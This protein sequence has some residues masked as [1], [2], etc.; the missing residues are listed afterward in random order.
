MADGEKFKKNMQEGA[1]ATK[2]A[3][4]AAES[5][6]ENIKDALFFSRD[7]ADEAKKAVKE[8]GD[9]S[10]AA[11]ETA[12]AFRD[13]ASAAKGITDNYAEVLTGEK[14]LQ[15]LIK[16]RQKL[17]AAQNSFNTEFEQELLKL[18]FTQEE[19]NS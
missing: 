13:V 6:K 12:K 11:S 10:I 8:I 5:L 3:S 9:G 14:T 19:I 1:K 18:R 17:N 7:Y 2:D 16:Q 15:D 4:K